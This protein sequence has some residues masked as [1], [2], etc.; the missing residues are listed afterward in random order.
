MLYTDAAIE[1]KKTGWDLTV[2]D[3]REIV[4]EA[5]NLPAVL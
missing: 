1:G 3:E 2:K 5:C 4:L